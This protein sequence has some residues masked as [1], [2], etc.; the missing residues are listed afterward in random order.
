M[1]KYIINTLNKILGIK[2][3][4]RMYWDWDNTNKKER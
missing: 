4:S 3:P 2:S 1:W